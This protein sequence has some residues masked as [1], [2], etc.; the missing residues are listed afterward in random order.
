M[1]LHAQIINTRKNGMC[2]VYIICY[3]NRER[4]R[5]KTN[6]EVKYNE[7]D[8]SQGVV[9]GYVKNAKDKNLLI[10]NIKK[11]ITEIEIRYRLRNLDFT[12]KDLKNEFEKPHYN[13]S[14]LSFYSQELEKRKT[15]ISIS[16]YQKYSITLKKLQKFR[17]EITFNDLNIDLLNDYSAFCKK[18]G[19]CQN[20]INANLKNIKYF[21]RLAYKK[22]MIL[23]DIF[24]DYK[25]SNI[26][27]HRN[28]LSEKE[29]YKLVDY[30]KRKIFTEKQ[31]KILR[32]FLFSC[33]TGLR[34]SDIENLRFDNI[35]EDTI[36][37]KPIKTSYLDKVVRIPLCQQAIDLIDFSIKRR[38][39]FT[40]F[41]SQY[42][43]RELKNI[44][45]MV[46]IKKYITFHCARHTFATFYLRKTKDLT[47]LQRLLGHAN[48]AD[49]MIYLHVIDDDLRV[50]I[51]ELDKVFT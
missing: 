29:L 37:I 12:A 39:V 36:I 16:M 24:T 42:I 11:Q 41:S 9:Y 34:F 28:F 43:N 32:P 45:D 15:A 19:N 48:L 6:V 10:N 7:F 17:N 46:D 3:I 20:T 35:V 30:Y 22:K 5:L 2:P 47:G 4:V 33:F 51:K 38:R 27:P 31:L 23:E 50:N 14:F 26:Q 13:T 1:R 8:R 18:T 44:L 40:L 25:I 49:T 21:V